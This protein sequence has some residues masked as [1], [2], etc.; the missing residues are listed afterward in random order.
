[1][2]SFR[3][4][5]LIVILACSIPKQSGVFDRKSVIFMNK[6][7]QIYLMDGPEGRPRRVRSVYG[8]DAQSIVSLVSYDVYGILQLTIG[9]SVK[10]ILL[11][12]NQQ[13]SFCYEEDEAF[14]VLD[15]RSI[16]LTGRED[17]LPHLLHFNGRSLSSTVLPSRALDKSIYGHS[18]LCL[19]NELIYFKSDELQVY[20][21]DKDSAYVI[22]PQEKETKSGN[23]VLITHYF[24]INKSRN[25][26]YMLGVYDVDSLTLIHDVM[27]DGLFQLDGQ[28]CATEDDGKAKILIR[29]NDQ[30]FAAGFGDYYLLD[31]SDFTLK[32]L[33]SFDK[34]RFD[35]FAGFIDNR[36]L[37][38]FE[39]QD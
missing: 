6:N 37:K 10:T 26:K 1:M 23:Y 16:L 8:I 24:V 14:D 7:K 32:A 13:Y 30:E 3:L 39:I 28:R 20:E 34:C 11:D 15:Q 29:R 19:R 21:I 17:S 27:L 25:G 12:S 33:P 38:I 4:L 5:L 2:E 36:H 31:L 9:D 18:P 22:L 35:F